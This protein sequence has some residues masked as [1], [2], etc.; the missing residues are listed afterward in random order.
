MIRKISCAVLGATLAIFSGTAAA[1]SH[2]Q[3]EELRFVPV[4]VYACN[5][6]AGKSPDDLGKVIGKW[7]AYM[8]D[9][10]SNDYAA[11]TMVPVHFSEWAFD[12][13]WVGV[14]RDG[15]AMGEG[16]QSYM[17]TGAEIGEEF[18]KV[19][20]CGSHS[21][22]SS[23]RMRA[24]DANDNDGQFVA[25]FSNCSIREGKKMSDA[26]EAMKAWNAARDEAGVVE[27]E[28]W[29]F[30][31]PG[32]DDLDA[33]FKVVSVISDWKTAGSNY[34]TVANGGV[35]RKSQPLQEALDCDSG[36][37][38]NVTQHRKMAEQD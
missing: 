20:K 14:W 15:N 25:A 27:G 1:D 10:K 34:Q 3:E 31:G 37:T 2:E 12:V 38:Y 7:N 5:Y 4:E 6:R 28:S 24:G 29:W 33:D 19:L 32:N 23:L 8:D 17:Q 9:N 30:P 18:N 35:W 21:I 16:I 36:R 22:Y 13:A 11:Y 26:S